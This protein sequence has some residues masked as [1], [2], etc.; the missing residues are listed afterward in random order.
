MNVGGQRR[1]TYS[2]QIRKE[3]LRG[4]KL[5]EALPGFQNLYHFSLDVGDFQNLAYGSLTSRLQEGGP[6]A[7]GA[8][9]DEQ[10]FYS[11]PLAWTV[12]PK[13]GREH[14]G[15]IQNQKVFTGEYFGQFVEE[16]MFPLAALPPY[17]HH[18]R[19]VAARE[20]TLGYEIC[21]Q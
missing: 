21:R 17:H 16:T 3:R 20:R 6:L 8:F 18:A 1:L 10:D 14:T 4:V 2:V 15:V 7:G 19:F 12:A 13:P 5:K 11:L 9:P